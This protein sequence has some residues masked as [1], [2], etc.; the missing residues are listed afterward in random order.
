MSEVGYVGEAGLS[1]LLG[2]QGLAEALEPCT[3]LSQCFNLMG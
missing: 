3:G 1:H 2:D